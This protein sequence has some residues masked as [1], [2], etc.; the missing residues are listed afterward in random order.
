MYSISGSMVHMLSQLM[1]Q[2][3]DSAGGPSNQP[4]HREW[5]WVHRWAQRGLWCCHLRNRVQKQRA[6][7][8]QGTHLPTQHSIS[9]HNLEKNT[10]DF[11]F[12]WEANDMLIYYSSVRPGH[13]SGVFRYVVSKSATSSLYCL[14]WWIKYSLIMH[15]FISR[16]HML[17]ISFNCCMMLRS[18]VPWVTSSNCG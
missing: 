9:L 2:E 16:F 8:A 12:F 6:F 14:V 4:V 1:Y 10:N 11:F 18:N 3:R 7:M 17:A 13:L 5:C 15:S